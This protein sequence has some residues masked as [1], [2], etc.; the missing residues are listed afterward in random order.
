MVL[1]MAKII[2]IGDV[3]GEWRQLEYV[4]R[5]IVERQHNPDAIIQ[6]GDFGWNFYV[7][8]TWVPDQELMEN[9]PFPMIAIDGNHEN[10]DLLEKN[11]GWGV[12]YFR[13]VKRGE[14]F[15]VGN[16]T[17]MGFGGATSIDRHHRI[18]GQTWWPQENITYRQVNE[19]LNYAGKIDLIVTHEKPEQFPGHDDI[20]KLNDGIG[21]RQALD[22]LYE[23]FK[24]NFWLY[25]HY[26]KARIGKFQNTQYACCPIVGTYQYVI[27]DTENQEINLV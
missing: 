8:D 26:H 11:N 20:H 18:H 4:L 9:L 25:G 17:C 5:K 23:Q 14:V 16:V 13:H 19:A 2:F 15:Q 3:H 21:D 10:F 22:A 12:N 27:V 24:P 6:V 7:N 1:E